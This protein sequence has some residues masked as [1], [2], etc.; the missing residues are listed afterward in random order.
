MSKRKDEDG[1]SAHP[2]ITTKRR[3]PAPGFRVAHNRDSE[4]QD[5]TS[6]TTTRTRQRLRPGFHAARSQEQENATPCTSSL[7][8]NSRITTLVLGANGRLKAKHKDRSHNP[9]VANPAS[10]ATTSADDATPHGYEVD[11]MPFSNFSGNP[12]TPPT[13]TRRKQKT[14]TNAQVCRCRT[15]F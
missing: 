5:A 10:I 2:P 1:P 6:S 8:T 12:T 9:S 7:T 13:E 4:P 11:S 15:L 3:R 14:T